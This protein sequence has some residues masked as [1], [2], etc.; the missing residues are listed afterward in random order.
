MVC[1]LSLGIGA[2]L[3]ECGGKVTVEEKLEFRVTCYPP[4]LGGVEL[5]NIGC[6]SSGNLGSRILTYPVH[7]EFIKMGLTNRHLTN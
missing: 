3:D 1:A 7:N 5:E 4:C 2:L 6:G